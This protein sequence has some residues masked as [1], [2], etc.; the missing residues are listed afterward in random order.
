MRP[1]L[2]DWPSEAFE[3]LA[4]GDSSSN[5]TSARE[6]QVVRLERRVDAAQDAFVRLR[7]ARDAGEAPQHFDSVDWSLVSTGTSHAEAPSADIGQ[8]NA[9]MVR[10]QAIAPAEMSFVAPT[11]K[12]VAQQA[13][14]STRDEAPPSAT[15]AAPGGDDDSGASETGSGEKKINYNDLATRIA[16][17]LQRRFSRE[18][19]RHGRG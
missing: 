9:T 12:A 8:L 13:Q 7:E 5:E 11:I 6:Q 4:S 3:F 10:Q 15:E 1:G 17:R 18:R 2:D 16:S 14:L 19:D